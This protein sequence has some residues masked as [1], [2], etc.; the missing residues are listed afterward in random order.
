MYEHISYEEIL[1]R[2]MSRVSNKLDKREGSVIWD[3]HSPAALEIMALYIELER[4][5]NE[6]FGDTA[7]REFLIRRCA[8]RGIK[9]YSASKAVCRGEFTPESVDVLGKRFN[10]GEINFCAVE[11]ISDGVYKME[12]EKAGSEGNHFIG[13][14]IPI[15]YINGL[16]TA[17][18]AELLI[19]GEDE[20]DTEELRR[21]YFDSF[22]D[23][24]FGGNVKD[25]ITK[26]NAIAGVGQTKVTRVWNGDIKPSELIPSATV[27][28][29]YD[30]AVNGLD[31][32]PKRWLETV[33]NAA[34]EKK[35]TAGGTVLL[36][37][38]GADFGEASEELVK[39]VQEE[40]DPEPY[41]G[42]GMGLAPIGHVV[43]VRSAE[44]VKVNIA[45]KIAF[46]A[47]YGFGNLKESIEKASEDYLLE[48]R[49]VWGSS[50]VTVVRISQIE[51]RL[52]SIKG[53]VDIGG[54]KINGAEENL[55]LGELQIPVLGGVEAD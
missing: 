11:K 16:Q 47:G 34:E 21:R 33:F 7:S 25:Y 22:E 55:T 23:K 27:K 1:N 12:C 40:I 2:M 17:E 36:T 13:Q 42:E 28:A 10:I 41:G 29:W 20:E 19:P 8:E 54:T 9:P 43:K 26:T 30:G 3:A 53:I 50:S 37:I 44:G 52:L 18:L 4:V 46:E 38:L 15:D 49:K 24:A 32:E 14:L 48:L 51:T 35:L 45:V 6:S 39:K 5:I 31:D